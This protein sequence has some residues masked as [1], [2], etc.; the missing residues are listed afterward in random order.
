MG[1]ADAAD[2]P[3]ADGVVGV[4][5]RGAYAVSAYSGSMHLASRVIDRWYDS[6]A[7]SC[8]KVPSRPYVESL[9][10]MAAP[11]H[12]V[13]HGPFGHFFDDHHLGQ[14]GVT[15]EDGARIITHELGIN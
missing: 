3:V 13:G 1:A 15:H 8:R 10:R 12:D 5:E 11:L 14:F 4:S 6:L 9:V 7:E 2:P